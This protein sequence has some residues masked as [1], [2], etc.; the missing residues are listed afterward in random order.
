MALYGGKSM[1]AAQ[2]GPHKLQDNQVLPNLPLVCA[3][4]TEA[5]QCKWLLKH[6]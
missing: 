3:K 4:A 5:G 2:E 1:E 6:D